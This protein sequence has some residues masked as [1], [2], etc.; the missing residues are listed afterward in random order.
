MDIYSFSARAHSYININLTRAINYASRT[1][2]LGVKLTPDSPRV[3]PAVH[4]WDEFDHRRRDAAHHVSFC[5][6]AS[7]WYLDDSNNTINTEWRCS[8][9]EW[10]VRVSVK[11]K[12]NSRIINDHVNYDD[13]LCKK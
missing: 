11:E 2:N 9:K 5:S 8:A 1:M 4:Y 3:S 7:I 10:C 12:N 13:M 6:S